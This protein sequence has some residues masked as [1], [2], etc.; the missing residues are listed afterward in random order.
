L[1]YALA[2]SPAVA[3]QKITLYSDE[4]KTIPKEV[5]HVS[6]FDSTVLAGPYE[7]YFIDGALKVK[8][9]YQNNVPSGEWELQ[10]P[11]PYYRSD[12]KPS[13]QNCLKTKYFLSC[14]RISRQFHCPDAH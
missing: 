5:F 1:C 6:L 9:N 11:Y 10:H 4:D 7:A 2:T 14:H 13:G 8:G 12:Q 3:Q